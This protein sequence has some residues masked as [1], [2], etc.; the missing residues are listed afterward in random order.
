[1]Y[2]T[3]ILALMPLV[4][5]VSHATA[6]TTQVFTHSAL[7]KKAQTVNVQ[8][9]TANGELRQSVALKLI[10]PYRQ[11]MI[12][13]NHIGSLRPNKKYNLKGLVNR[14][15]LQY[16]KQRVGINLGWT[17]NA[18]PN[19]AARRSR[20]IFSRKSPS[21]GPIRYG[22][23]LAL[24]WHGKPFIKYKKR[25]FGINLNWSRTP[26]YEWVI[27]GGRPG[28][29]V[30]GGKDRVVIYNLKHQQPLIHFNRTAGGDIGW[31]D[32]RTWQ[33][34]VVNTIGKHM[35]IENVVK[36]LLIAGGL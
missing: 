10:G 22:E 5:F 29:P 18:H 16:E 3:G 19:T 27:L 34:Q 9:T 31:P 6:Q 8:Q 12:G 25:R 4:M 32:S 15:F 20:F 7:Q 36:V 1:M 13:A 26:S 30:M 11:W 14:K 24:A 21:A 2:R 28:Q 33:R 17:D 35:K 23:P